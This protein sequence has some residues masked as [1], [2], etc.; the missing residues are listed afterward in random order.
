MQVE[1]ALSN[2]LI[3][4]SQVAIISDI[5]KPAALK[6]L[7]RLHGSF[8]MIF[9]DAEWTTGSEDLCKPRVGRIRCFVD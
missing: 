5:A 3:L 8:E 1:A 9:N 7:L 2:D 4:G 6:F